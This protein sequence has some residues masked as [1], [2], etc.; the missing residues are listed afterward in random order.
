MSES[1]GM[2]IRDIPRLQALWSELAELRRTLFHMPVLMCAT[3][4]AGRFVFWNRECERV[5]GYRA[6]EMVGN[7]AAFDLLIPDPEAR[8]RA[9]RA[10][11]EGD[12]RNVEWEIVHS[13]GS[14]RTVAW[15]SLARSHPVN[16]WSSWAVGIDLTEQRRT[17]RALALVAEVN[18]LILRRD[19]LEVIH[20]RI[21][22]EL[23]RLLALPLVCIGVREGDGSVR[24]SGAA[25]VNAPFVRGLEMR[26]DRRDGTGLTARAIRTG[27]LQRSAFGG[28]PGFGRWRTPEAAAGVVASAALPLA[29]RGRVLGALTLHA[30]RVDSFDDATLALL[31]RLTE[32]VSLSLDHAADLQEIELQ[33]MALEAAGHAVAVTDRD[34]RVVFVN[35]SFSALTG[36]GRDEL[37]GRLLRDVLPDVVDPDVDEEIW[38]IL[39]SGGS[40]R[41]ERTTRR[42]DG[43]LFVEDETVTPVRAPDGTVTRVVAIKRDV[44]ARK[45]EE[46]RVVHLARHDPLTDLPNRRVVEEA[47]QRLLARA[48]RGFPSAVL[49]LDLDGFK[50]VND[51]YG[52]ATGD[53]VLRKLAGVFRDAVRPDDLVG[54]IG[55]D[56]FVVLLE[57]VDGDEARAAAE[58]LRS[59]VAL[60]GG[61]EA[62]P[63]AGLDACVGIALV[64]GDLGTEAVLARADRALYEAK[65]LGK[66][67]VV[68]DAGSHPEAGA[69]P[70]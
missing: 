3:D 44:T 25:G 12:F 33:S 51:R 18:R 31:L 27:E 54:R 4:D 50:A 59:R 8:A 58:R 49:L 38:R 30:A 61:A 65:A 39:R 43:T 34:G 47:L 23:A 56:E 60:A 35:D 20:G 14:T 64:D 41:G 63:Q 69:R 42:R 11:R 10:V 24:L 67:Q 9:L 70:A 19:P 55:G 26:W 66:G 6:D 22:E 13:D 48:A 29:A 40:W 57:G 15:S 21:C 1:P 5:T 36:W 32:Q 53:S 68:V 52:H 45:R 62:G 17:E 28:D 2:P 16:G 46:E 37:S 7:A